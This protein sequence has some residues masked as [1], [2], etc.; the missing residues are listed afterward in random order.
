MEIE[1]TI[2][3]NPQSLRDVIDK[4]E[5]D[6]KYVEFKDL[7]CSLVQ[8]SES[9][10]FY[11]FSDGEYFWMT[12]RQVGSCRPG[13]RDSNKTV[14]DLQPFREG[15]V[16]NDYLLCQALNE[17]IGWYEKVFKRKPE[18]Y[19]DYCYGLIANKW[20][21]ETFDGSIGLIGAGPKLDAIKH[22]C[23]KQEYLDYLKFNGFTDYVRMPQNH[24]CDNLDLGEQIL[25]EE[26]EKSKSKIF[27]VGIGHAQQAL[28]H[29][30][31]KYKD[32]V[33]IVV[34]SGICAYAGVQDNIR[35]YF[36]DWVNFRSNSIDYS[37]IDIWRQN[38]TKLK[39]I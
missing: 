3:N 29:R 16:K 31:K 5:F 6:K 14:R 35:P 10:T 23:T 36:A 4:K 20:F 27:L 24:L 19:V 13:G 28:L 33:Y 39:V 34:G 22:L 26:L 7:L 21:T 8:K 32:A 17:H 2:N 9:K 25:K 38:F 1:G 15:V 37:K 18:Y 11:K 30:M 12:D